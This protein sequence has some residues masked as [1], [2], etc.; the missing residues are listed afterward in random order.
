[1]GCASSKSNKK[2]ADDA[3]EERDFDYD[4]SESSVDRA[5]TVSSSRGELNSK[6]PRLRD[7]QDK[8]YVIGDSI[9]AKGRQESRHVDLEPASTVIDSKSSSNIEDLQSPITL[10]SVEEN[11]KKP[12]NKQ[13][14]SS[15][16]SRAREENHSR[17]TTSF[18]ESD[19]AR[20]YDAKASFV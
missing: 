2:P 19:S 16:V 8:F 20:Y 3:W 4:Y 11:R 13:S 12:K 9:G 14:R 15:R 1:M 5:R 10:E 6:S 17:D 7:L 18:S